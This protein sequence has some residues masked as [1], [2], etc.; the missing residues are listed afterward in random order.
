MTRCAVFLRGVNVGGHNKLVMRDLCE[1]LEKAEFSSVSTYIQS[2]NIVLDA[3]GPAR[4]V[5]N[6]VT[7]LI[8][9]RF[10]ITTDAIAFD[11][12]GLEALVDAADAPDDPAR[13]Y[14]HM[15]LAGAPDEAELSD[16]RAMATRNE[17]LTL[18]ENALILTA[19]DGIAR[20]RLAA[21]IPDALPVTARN[22][23]TMRRM[24]DMLRHA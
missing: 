13:V 10:S 21:K 12:I 1:A 15:F 18:T 16:L 22:L 6:A 3:E 17:R 5:A 2:G 24:L 14:I 19:P 20:S 11:Q 7:G 4:S 9:R 8:A 23:R